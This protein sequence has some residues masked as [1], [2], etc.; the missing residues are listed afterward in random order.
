MPGAAH[1]SVALLRGINVGSANRIS[2]ADLRA[3]F[4]KLGYTDVTT[5]LQSGNVVFTSHRELGPAATI[6]LEDE[7]ANTTGV[8]ARI[9]VLSAARFLEIARANP[10]VSIADNDSMLI[11][12]FLGEPAPASVTAPSGIAPEVLEI[13]D[14]AI[15][16]WCPLGLSKS[17]VPPAFF[18]KLGAQATAR[19]WRTVGKIAGLLGETV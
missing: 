12:T 16:Q 19:N 10:L 6:A 5:L 15:Y 8:R 2:M 13:G 7:L 14:G 1:T 18:T 17:I 11:V 9:L 4:E 3:I